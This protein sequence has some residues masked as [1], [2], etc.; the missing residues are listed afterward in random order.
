MLASEN[1][2]VVYVGEYG[3]YLV[4]QSV[5]ENAASLNNGVFRHDRRT[6]SWKHVERWG[7]NQ[8][9]NNETIALLNKYLKKRD[10]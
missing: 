4:P 9:V 3:D 7:R 8:D 1:G 5:M 6:R 2:V 10:S